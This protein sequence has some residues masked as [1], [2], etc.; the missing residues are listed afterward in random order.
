VAKV[1][2]IPVETPQFLIEKLKLPLFYSKPT[3]FSCSVS[4]YS[5][6][7]MALSSMLKVSV[8]KETSIIQLKFRDSTPQ[9]ASTCLLAVV[10]DIKTQQK[11]LSVPIINKIKVQISQLEYRLS[12]LLK[13]KN[14]YETFFL[15]SKPTAVPTPISSLIL[16]ASYSQFGD[17]GTLQGSIDYQ[18]NL[19]ELPDT[20]DAGLIFPVYAPND[21]VSPNGLLWLVAGGLI[22][23]VLGAFSFVV[24]TILRRKN[25]FEYSIKAK[26]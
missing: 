21:K 6:P 22:G 7:G 16:S 5:Q 14:M 4:G 23:M 1:A 25:N 13:A 9:K 10:N 18:K 11:L 2:T 20:Q 8:S 26:S 3:L 24:R 17:I 15:K 19:L 12:E